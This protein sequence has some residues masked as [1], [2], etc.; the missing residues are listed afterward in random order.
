MSS[1]PAAPPTR[2]LARGGPASGSPVGTVDAGVLATVDE[3]GTVQLRDAGW[4]L[5]WWIGAEDR[6]H[7][8]PVEAA[9][10]Q[11]AVSAT[12]VRETAMRVPGGDVVQRV[13]GV[14]ATV[15]GRRGPAVLVEVENR[16]AV[17]VALALVVRPLVLDGPGR[18]VSAGVDGPVVRVDGRPAVL[19]D[20]PAARA[21][22]GSCRE[23]AEG[24]TVAERLAAGDDA[25]PPLARED[26]DGRAELAVV[27]P[28]AHTAT[29][30]L[31]LP[32]GPLL[33]IVAE[34]GDGGATSW[35]A[36]A[37]ESVV[38]GWTRHRD[39]APRLALG[40]PGWSDA[41]AWAGSLLALA[42]A[43]E[44][45]AAL[46]RELVGRDGTAAVRAAAVAE[47]LT[48][49]GADDALLPIARGLAAAQGLRGRCRLGD[50]TDGSVALL[51]AAAGVLAGPRAEAAAEELVAPAAVAVRRVR[52][53]GP[54][55]GVAASVAAAALRAVTPGLVR[56][57]QPEVAA[58]AL[59]LSLALAAS[60]EGAGPWDGA[61]D[62]P[63]AVALAARAA[64]AGGD[65]AAPAAV[66]ALWDGA[67][68]RLPLGDVAELAMR[69]AALLDLAALDDAAGSAVLP[70][71]APTWW[72]VPME[73]HGLRTA[74][75][76]VSWALRWHGDRP[77]LLW[78]VEPAE[79]L[80]EDPAPALTA[81]GLDP[82]WRGTGWQ[83][84]ALLEAPADAP[85]SAP[86]APVEG[87]SFS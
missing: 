75:G 79:G 63:V 67:E 28:L 44:V 23:G 83:G 30:R 18:V 45:G 61:G 68:D 43:D 1:A 86:P 33:S 84:E 27:V 80:G 59:S 37:F 60:P 17:P 52:T 77:A 48:R 58:D 14:Q 87:Q 11:Q 20:R 66:R 6:W 81:A 72:G 47:V 65:P 78:E 82:S 2:A 55:D 85:G 34:A 71:V 49:S 24:G 8:P 5:D 31:L 73:A 76:T 35:E 54:G 40:E 41:V 57:G 51:W 39:D 10:R 62:S 46:D 32:A 50:R 13:A 12:P 15:A 38:A 74:W 25:V 4:V 9:V 69:L 22:A 3:A 64:I 7:H 36:P 26:R 70:V 42:G 21:V 29:V 53:H 19:L 56:V 16:T